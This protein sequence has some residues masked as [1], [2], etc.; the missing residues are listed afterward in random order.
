M[1]IIDII[2]NSLIDKIKKNYV[3]SQGFIPSKLEYTFFDKLFLK[4]FLSSFLLLSI[5]IIEKIK[6]D[7]YINKELH[8]SFNLIYIIDL[9]NHKII[10]IDSDKLEEVYS[11]SFY[12]YVIYE[13]NV[14]RVFNGSNE[15]KNLISGYV[16][17][18]EKDKELYNVVI[19]SIDG[20]EYKY[21]NLESINVR[22]Y[23]YVEHNKILGSSCYN[24]IKLKY[25]F[26]LVIS[27]YNK[28]YN[29]YE[30]SED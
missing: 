27:D 24:E 18:I 21:C 3:P 8:S 2:K 5:S 4:I 10:N 26:L 6:L 20:L 16:I 23:E 14:N 1:E 9:F 28:Y 12:E 7:N 11:S 13:N 17:K 25:E 19:K 15:V 22:M 29:Y 30:K